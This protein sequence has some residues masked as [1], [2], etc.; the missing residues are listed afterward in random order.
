LTGDPFAPARRA[1]VIG[2]LLMLVGG[3]IVYLG[4]AGDGLS[5]LLCVL[6]GLVALAGLL[7]LIGGITVLAL[8]GRRKRILR[9]GEPS[10]A[11]V[12]SA[13]QLGT[14]AGYPIY[15]MA[16]AIPSS[17]GGQSIVTKRGAI[18]PQFAGS[19]EAGI[20]LPIKIR[21][22]DQAF[23]VDWDAL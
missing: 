9:E 5:W 3:G 6:G 7:R 21:P 8:E 15:E 14:K 13:K 11:T 1:L 10:T 17:E 16:L 4:I 22:E 18:P 20:E 12:D 2:P 19:L 23:A